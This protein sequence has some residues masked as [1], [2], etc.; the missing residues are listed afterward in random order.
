MFIVEHLSLSMFLGKKLRDDVL[1]EQHSD[2]PHDASKLKVTEYLCEIAKFVEFPIVIDEEGKRTI[3]LHPD[4]PQSNADA[5]KTDGTTHA[6][7]QLSKE[8]AWDKE[9]APQ[10]AQTA[11]KCLQQHT[12]DL[13]RELGLSDYEGFFNL[14]TPSLRIYEI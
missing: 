6:V 7:N 13:K 1:E 12:L 4:R 5:F 3:I 11:Q 9:F 8:Y 10:D 2:I 14:Y